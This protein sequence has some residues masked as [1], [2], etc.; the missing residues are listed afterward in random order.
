MN[1]IINEQEIIMTVTRQFLT[2][3]HLSHQDF[4]VNLL[5]PKMGEIEPKDIV[6]WSRWV[7]AHKK[8][9]QR[10][11]SLELDMPL[12]LKWFWISALPN[13][14]ATLVKERLNA[15]QGYTLPL[16]V[17]SSCDSV[18]SGVP[19]LLS[20]SAD[21]AKNLEPAYD[22]IYDEHDSLEASNKLI[23]SLLRSAVTYVEEAR[24]VHNGTG[25]T[26]SD[27]NVKDFKF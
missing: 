13:K 14:Y 2:E 19:E 26:G 4:A 11:L 27:F 3:T 9:V 21:I 5:A 16:P 17:L 1:N 23:D 20:A 25:A 7:G 12:K 24:K 10:Y 15:A 6:D 8:R 18:V 22:G